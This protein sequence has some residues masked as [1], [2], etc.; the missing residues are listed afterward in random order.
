MSVII[1]KDISMK[2]IALSLVSFL[3][4]ASTPSMRA[5]TCPVGSLSGVAG[6]P[7]TTG[8]TTPN[9]ITYSPLINGNLF[10]AA[11]NGGNSKLSVWQANTTTGVFSE[12]SP[13]PLGNSDG[14]GNNPSSVAYSPVFNGRVYVAVAN[15]GSNSVSIFLSDP[16]TGVLTA[17]PGSPFESPNTPFS[18]PI[19]VAYSPVL[20]NNVYLAITNGGSNTISVYSINQTTG[21]LSSQVTGSPFSTGTSPNTI[22]FSPLV[23]GNLFA[24]VTTGGVNNVSIYQV[25]TTTG[26]FALIQTVAIPTGI[27][28]AAYSPVVNGDLF[29]AVTDDG[30]LVYVYSVN[31]TTGLLSS[32]VSG[33]PFTVINATE[34]YGVTFSPV[35]NGQLFAAVGNFDSNDVT[36]YQVNTTTGVFT[37][38]TGPFTAGTDPATVAFS[39]I[40]SGG[41]FLAAANFVSNNVS[42]FGVTAL[43]PII[44][45]PSF[46]T[47]RGTM[48][49]INATI[50][51]GTSPFTV[52]WNDGLIQTV[53]ATS[54]SRTVKAFITSTYYILTVSDN[55]GCVAGPSNQV[56]IGV[57]P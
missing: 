45:T 32:Q 20:N 13:F 12:V 9:W 36:M 49:T 23:N 55:L 2:N 56:T 1:K 29:A 38:I 5:I 39:P 3:M 33:S 40:V 46:Y 16:T 30:N 4:L 34:A 17:V 26:V 27:G 53:N 18:G 44:T 28:T 48:V 50:G 42:V 7:F 21:A 57:I 41:L 22:S 37:K 6:S 10:A 19:A 15:E 47:S 54:L 24:L 8:G 51:D 43:N 35:F 25:N 11:T 31:T 14:I 52:T